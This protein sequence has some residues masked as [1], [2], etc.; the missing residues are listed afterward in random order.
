MSW[1][2]DFKQDLE[3]AGFAPGTRSAYLRSALAFA[4][5]SS[6]SPPRARQPAVR[7]W[8]RH[9]LASGVG[10]QRLRC[11]F[12][13]LRFLFLRTLGLPRVVSFLA[14]P[15]DVVRAPEVLSTEEVAGCLRGVE[16]ATHRRCLELLY[17]T[18]VRLAEALAI[19]REDVDVGRGLIR[20]AHGKGARE[21]YVPLPRRLGPTLLDASGTRG[22]EPAGWAL[23]TPDSVRRALRV[24][25]LRAGIAR[26]IS[27]R[28][29]RH[30]FATHQVDL[31]TDLRLLQVLL[32]HASIR[33]TA[34]YAHVS[35]ERIAACPCLLGRLGRNQTSTSR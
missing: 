7:A 16:E 27:P 26:R 24:A 2:D 5:F 13:A 32:G 23:L 11:H 1:M 29:F 33:S 31:G 34:R 21:R 6:C 19:R 22:A 35:P 8:V 4:R 3:L 30:A 14:W 17:A 12:A 25:A 18:G 9:L 15:R 20:I 28:D 10:P